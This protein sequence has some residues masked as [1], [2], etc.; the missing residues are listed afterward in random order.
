MSDKP[1]RERFKT[2]R[3][4]L[5]F[6]SLFE[7]RQNDLGGEPRYEAQLIFDEAAMKDPRFQKMKEGA[8]RC[9]SE[10]WG[11]KRP[12][13]M[14]SPFRDGSEKEFDGYGPGTSYITASSH[15]KPPALREDREEATKEDLYPGCYVVAFVSPYAYDKK[16]N[17]GVAFGL[18]SIMKVADGEPLSGGGMTVQSAKDAFA[19][20]D[21]SEPQPRRQAGSM[22]LD[23]TPPSQG[24]GIGDD[25][26]PF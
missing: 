1:E 6:P 22:G 15:S 9:A 23:E 16:G 24:M 14:R 3:A 7:K 19:D 26:I 12:A 2:P 8:A 21:A 13:N 20:E 17:R 4:R 11:S 5:S 10:K 25:E 18:D